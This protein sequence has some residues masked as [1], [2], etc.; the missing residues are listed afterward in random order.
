MFTVLK[1]KNKQT[2]CPGMM[3][4]HVLHVQ[5]S[6]AQTMPVNILKRAFLS[7]PLGIMIFTVD[8]LFPDSISFAW[9]N[10]TYFLLICSF[11]KA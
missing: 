10:K 2:N 6:G 11:I 4:M 5:R 9:V 8:F 1:N 7:I 3:N